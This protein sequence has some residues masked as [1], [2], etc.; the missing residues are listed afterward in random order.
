[1]PKKWTDCVKRVKAASRRSGK[2][3]NAYAVC[4]AST[5][6]TRREGRRKKRR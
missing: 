4:T 1:M 3:V 2:K 6:L 5:G